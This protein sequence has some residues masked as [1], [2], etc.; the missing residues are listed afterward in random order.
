[1]SCQSGIFSEDERL[2]RTVSRFAVA[3][4]A[5]QRALEDYDD[6]RATAHV[7]V[8]SGLYAVLAREGQAGQDSFLVLLESDDDVVAGMAAVYSL[9]YATETALAVLRR[10]GA[11]DSLLGF[12][13]RYALERWENGEWQQP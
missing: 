2:A 3:A 7:R 1:M 11:E 4:R 12:R 9:L 6:E 10:L 13:A 8:L 5:H